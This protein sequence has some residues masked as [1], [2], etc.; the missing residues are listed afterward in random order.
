MTQLNPSEHIRLIW[1]D[2]Y[3]SVGPD[4]QFVSVDQEDLFHG[5]SHRANCQEGPKKRILF[6]PQVTVNVFSTGG[7]SAGGLSAGGSSAGGSSAGGSGTGGSGTGGAATIN[8]NNA[9]G[10]GDPVSGLAC[11]LAALSKK[12]EQLSLLASVRG[13]VVESGMWNTMD[14]RP[15]HQ[16]RHITEGR[17]N[18]SKEFK[19]VP[20]V[21]V[22]MCS[23]DVSERANFRVKVY[24]TAVDLK[25]FTVH[26]DS[27]GDTQLYS[28]GVSWMAMGE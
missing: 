7:S 9:Y 8:G 2:D 4:D 16:P 27:W 18:F 21:T 15:W 23:A 22:S 25:G 10:G 11:Q 1:P 3:V 12:V 24:A 20:T 14:V 5:E 6:R 26:A 28:C 13:V 19:S 17:V